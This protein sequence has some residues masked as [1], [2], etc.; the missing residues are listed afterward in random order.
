MKKIGNFEV[1]HQNNFIRATIKSNV[2]VLKAVPSFGYDDTIGTYYKSLEDRN[3]KK[4]IF[5]YCAYKNVPGIY[6]SKI[7]D[8]NYMDIYTQATATIPWGIST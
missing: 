8:S 4:L 1:N 6:L 3:F 7:D 2:L 5:N